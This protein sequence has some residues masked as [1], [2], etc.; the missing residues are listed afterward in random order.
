MR[1]SRE[2]KT[3]TRQRIVA[4]ALR[5]FAARGFAAT[6]IDDI[7]RE[8]ELTRGGF[9]AHFASKSEL[10]RVAI[11]DAGALNALSGGETGRRGR[12]G[13]IDA[14]LGACLTP[15]RLAFF[16]TD[17]ASDEP[18]VRTAY[19]DAFKSM[20]AK[21][22]GCTAA[23]SSCSEESVLSATAMIIG[24]LAVAHT[25]D[26]TD[27]RQK[28]LASCREN[29]KALLEDGNRYAAPILFWAPGTD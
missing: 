22:R 3:R 20:S 24:T 27:L 25:T 11:G 4:S 16:A 6:S 10:Y 18:E 28:L 29:A 2:Q 23:Q 13:R 14:M 26:D 21:I 19:T 15:D 17:V 9:Y 8:C 1:Y 7:M 12:D 5:L